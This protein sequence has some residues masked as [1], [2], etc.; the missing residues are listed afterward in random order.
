MLGIA[1]NN[2]HA[3]V[4]SPDTQTADIRGLQGQARSRLPLP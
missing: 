2:A 1:S 3:L 4:A